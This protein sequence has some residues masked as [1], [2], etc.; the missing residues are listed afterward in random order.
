MYKTA[1]NVRELVEYI[2]NAARCIGS[3]HCIPDFHIDDISQ[4]CCIKVIGKEFTDERDA[5]RYA[6]S[7]M[8][9]LIHDYHRSNKAHEQKLEAIEMLNI[10]SETEQES[11]HP[12]KYIPKRALIETIFEGSGLTHKEKYVIKSLFF[13]SVPESELAREQ[14]VRP[15]S[16]RVTKSRALSKMKNFVDENPDFPETCKLYNNG[17]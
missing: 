15:V 2:I 16:I 11:E 17:L 7:T 10:P 4:E 5:E 1:E 12:P 3:R 8:I 6:T 9:G 14:G 13:A